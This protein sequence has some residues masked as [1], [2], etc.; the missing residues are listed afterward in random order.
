MNAVE[1]F[2]DRLRRQE[3]RCDYVKCDHTREEIFTVGRENVL[4][5]LLWLKKYIGNCHVYSVMV[6]R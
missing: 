3:Q 6:D 1:E 2:V 4:K 5:A